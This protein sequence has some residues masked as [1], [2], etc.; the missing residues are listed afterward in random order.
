MSQCQHIKEN[1]SVDTASGE[2][3]CG[4]CGDVLEA[5]DNQ[6]NRLA[7]DD[8]AEP[9]ANH[10]RQR[11]GIKSGSVTVRGVQNIRPHKFTV[12]TFIQQTNGDS[13]WETFSVIRDPQRGNF[14]Q[15][16]DGIEAAYQK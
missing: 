16:I 8:V 15:V 6:P 2:L 3:F 11:P 1:H 5:Y 4:D 10:V 13:S 7:G 12:T 14:L 9:I